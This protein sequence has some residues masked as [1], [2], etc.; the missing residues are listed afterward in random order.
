LPNRVLF[1]VLTGDDVECCAN[2]FAD[3]CCATLDGCSRKIECGINYI[4]N[5][6]D[7][8]GNCL[9]DEIDGFSN[10]LCSSRKEITHIAPER[11]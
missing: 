4:S 5:T 10:S 7:Y 6:A 1:T 8:A 2:N 11:H 3:K 9:A